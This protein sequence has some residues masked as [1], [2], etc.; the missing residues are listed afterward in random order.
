MDDS[1]DNSRSALKVVFIFSLLLIIM[2]IYELYFSYNSLIDFSQSLFPEVFDQCVKYQI[3]TQMFFTVFAA[4]A[5]FSACIMSF[6][7][8]VN[9][10]LFIY[11]LLETIIY[12]NF[13]AFGPLLLGLSCFGFFN[14]GKVCIVC[15]E[16]DYTIQYVNFV[17]V[18][19]LVAAFFL[20]LLITIWYSA[21]G[22]IETFKNSIKFTSDGNYVIGKM[23][24][25]I[26]FNR[27]IQLL[28]GDDNNNNN[29]DDDINE[30]QRLN[31]RDNNNNNYDY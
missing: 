10:Q 5:G 19:F 1:D 14:F 24:W 26:V 13:Y 11:K 31:I 28:R 7:M 8:L 17:T 21:V 27:G 4:L 6:F 30:H 29:R 12:Y 3:I 20:S 9:Y 25:K 23:F 18:I 2:D 15:D 22:G 16:D